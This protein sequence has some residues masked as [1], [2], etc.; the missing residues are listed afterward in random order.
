VKDH[1]TNHLISLWAPNMYQFKGG[2]QAF[3]RYLSEAI[4][5]LGYDLEISLLHEHPSSVPT[6]KV[7]TRCFGQYPKFIRSVAFST[8][9]IFRVTKNKPELLISTHLNFGPAMILP[10]LASK[11]PYWLVAHGVDAWNVK[12]LLRRTA[13]RN[14]NKILAVSRYTRERLIKE[15]NI[16][17]EKIEIL[18]NTF[19]EER[20]QISDKSALLLNRYNLARDTVI[21]LSVCR[22]D[23]DEQ[24][25]GYDLILEALPSIISTQPNVKYIAVGT[26]NDHLRFQDKISKLGLERHV[27]VAGRVSDEELPLYYQT[28]DLFVMPSMGEG[29][30]IV[31]LEALACG[32]PVIA[33]NLDG[34]VDPLLDGEIGA[35]IDPRSSD[36][37]A[38]TILA[39]INKT[40]ANKNIFNAALLR[41]KVIQNFGKEAFKNKIQQ[42]LSGQG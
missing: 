41:S 37:L 25:K 7:E 32:K 39:I 21:L 8:S 9:N 22:F 23:S 31:F 24:Y 28:C 36:K 29:F 33:G 4:N 34:S 27:I 18:P 2:I 14:A 6:E 5:Q 1:K 11:A 35:L 40:Y 26:G 3:S 38:E 12:G 15:L 42:Y 16:D 10:S 30:G 17:N 19:D 13:L 20:F